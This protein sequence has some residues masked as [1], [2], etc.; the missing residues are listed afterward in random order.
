[1]DKWL[2][3]I[4]DK[5]PEKALHLILNVSEYVLPKLNKVEVEETPKDEYENMTDEELNAELKRFGIQ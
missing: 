5:N 3:E 4:A 2:N 1:M